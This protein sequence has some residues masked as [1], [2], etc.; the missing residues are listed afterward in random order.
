MENYQ[1]GTQTTFEE[2]L[3]QPSSFYQGRTPLSILEEISGG[4]VTDPINQ[5]TEQLPDPLAGSL[6][7]AT[8]DMGGFLLGAAPVAAMLSGFT[9][10]LAGAIEAG[11][12]PLSGLTQLA[13][14]GGASDAFTLGLDAGTVL[15]GGVGPTFDLATAGTGLPSLST[16]GTGASLAGTAA[17]LADG[18]G[19]SGEEIPKVTVTGT[20]DPSLATVLSGANLGATVAGLD[21]GAGE[22]FG[23]TGT[24]GTPSGAEEDF[25]LTGNENITPENLSLLS[26]IA[27]ALGMTPDSLWK[28]LGAIAPAALGAFGASQQSNALEQLARDQMA[29]E[30]GRFTTLLGREDEAIKRQ[31]AAIEWARSQG[32]PYR[33][34]LSDLIANPSSFLQSPGVQSSVQQGTD[35]LSRALSAKVG[36]PIGNMTALSDIQGYSTNALYSKLAEEMQRLG[37]LGG[38]S[39]AGTSGATVPG[40]G[41]NLNQ[42]VQDLSGKTQAAAIGADSNIW[43]AVGSGLA[44]VFNPQPSL[45]DLLKQLQGSN[46]FTVT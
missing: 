21:S 43:N 34:Q 13:G 5:T 29:L 10:A 18:G 35:A 46:I 2:W 19:G 12:T 44:N 16:L 42:N 27:K 22:D 4:V 15:E 45:S 38:L 24:E 14:S 33:K 11:T 9:P 36:N 41:T 25:G 39:P 17:T 26:T 20:Q 3:A 6:I 1:S 28:L 23:L 40:I 7:P 37:V 31:Q 32:A 8:E 30:Q